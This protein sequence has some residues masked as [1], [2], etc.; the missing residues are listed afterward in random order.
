MALLN[1]V[2]D[3]N[4]IERKSARFGELSKGEKAH[5]RA[6]IL[7]LGGEIEEKYKHLLHTSL[8]E[9]TKFGSLT[10]EE[11]N[12]IGVYVEVVDLLVGSKRID[13]RTQVVR[14]LFIFIRDRDIISR[15]CLFHKTHNLSVEIL[16]KFYDMSS[17]LDADF[18][19]GPSMLKEVFLG[20]AEEMTA[21]FPYLPPVPSSVRAPYN[22]RKRKQ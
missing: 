11:I 21:R 6:K 13:L 3:A 2:M 10:A 18:P 5:M 17:Y 14:D 20:Y 9:H 15:I 16:K 7:L 4:Y 8:P 1:P 12:E 19:Q 22:L